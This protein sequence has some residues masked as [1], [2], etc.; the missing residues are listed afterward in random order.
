LQELQQ[1]YMLQNYVTKI[2][3]T[4]DSYLK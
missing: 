3:H 4:S 1:N 2:R